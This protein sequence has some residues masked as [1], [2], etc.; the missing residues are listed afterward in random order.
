MKKYSILFV[1][2][3]A[4]SSAFAN[5]IGIASGAPTGTQY[6]MAENIVSTCSNANTHITNK[7]TEGALDN[8]EKIYSDPTT[9][10]GIIPVDA[11]FYQQGIDPKMMTRIQ[12][13]FSF[14]SSEF[15]VIKKAGSNI[16]SLADLQ[17]K[18][19][20]EGPRGSGTWVSSQV[21]KSLTGINWVAS[22][23]SQTAGLKAVLDG[24]VDA[25]I[26][27]AGKPI[28]LLS[29]TKSG[30]EL[31]SL[32]H[33][34]LD[35]FGLYTKSIIPSNTYPFQKSSVQSYKVDTIL[36][37]YAFKNQYQKEIGDLV[38]C[39]TKNIDTLQKTGHAKWRDVDPTDITRIK[40]PA[41]PAA[42]AAIKRLTK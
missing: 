14:Y 3:M 36:A 24:S 38:T 21:V 19:V 1:L 31:V 37:T 26:I 12:M 6:P 8:I 20:V 23:A 13:V 11:L 33:P 34:K 41:H 27:W 29:N 22:N 5:D 30:V 28:D 18:R 40:W 7:Q 17:G 10:Y 32:S 39:I 2:A 35:A 4:A 42:L 15:H 16:N 25:E 9:Q